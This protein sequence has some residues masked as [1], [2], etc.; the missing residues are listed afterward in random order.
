MFS[1]ITNKIL[2]N[3][4]CKENKTILINK[5]LF[6]FLS[7]NFYFYDLSV[8]KCSLST[9]LKEEEKFIL[10]KK[11]LLARMLVN[12]VFTEIFYIYYKLS[13]KIC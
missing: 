8:T 12:T 11:N 5:K 1:I 13:A 10:Q 2:D 6:N 4:W 7:Q 3:E 9:Q